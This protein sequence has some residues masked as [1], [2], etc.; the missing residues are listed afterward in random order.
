MYSFFT[1]HTEE[2]LKSK[3]VDIEVQLQEFHFGL[4]IDSGH[5]CD[6]K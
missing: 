1:L 4:I 5:I 3:A 6:I 2:P